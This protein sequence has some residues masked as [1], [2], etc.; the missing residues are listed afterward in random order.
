VSRTD[1]DLPMKAFIKE[2]I[3]VLNKTLTSQG[4]LFPGSNL[5]GA[6]STFDE[7]KYLKQDSIF[8]TV[9]EPGI[10]RILYT[11]LRQPER[12]KLEKMTTCI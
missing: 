3:R 10:F 8:K 7:S 1:V 9:Y 4:S 6:A 12:K 2:C 11:V 5:E